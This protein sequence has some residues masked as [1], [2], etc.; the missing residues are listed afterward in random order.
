MARM[1]A[2]KR[3]K[4]GSKKP[5]IPAQWVEFK[6]EEVER[7]VVKLAKDG[8]PTAQIGRTLRDQYGIPSVKAIA[9][10]TV[11]QIMKDNGITKDIPEDLLN[12]LKKAV[13]LN[14][15]MAKNKKDNTSK[16][17]RELL[18]SKIRRLGKYYVKTKKLPKDWRYD[19]ERAKL[20]VQTAK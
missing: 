5:A 19:A 16:R 8:M 14:E 17:G 20:I 7:L 18:E 11:L 15:H 10:K 1:Y 6:K 12:L 3:G 2:R 4:S 9:K 13:L